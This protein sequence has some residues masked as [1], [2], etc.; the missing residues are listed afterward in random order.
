MGRVKDEVIQLDEDIG[1]AIN[2]MEKILKVNLAR[3]DTMLFE[4]ADNETWLDFI[5][6]HV[7]DFGSSVFSDKDEVRNHIKNRASQLKEDMKYGV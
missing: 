4:I 7:N 1:E 5:C 3:D 6:N 2:K